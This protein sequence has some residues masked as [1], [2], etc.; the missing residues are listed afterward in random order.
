[1]DDSRPRCWDVLTGMSASR[2]DHPRELSESRKDAEAMMERR[3][4]LRSGV[5]SMRP[6]GWS[7]GEMGEFR[8]RFLQDHKLASTLELCKDGVSSDHLYE[9][10][11]GQTRPELTCDR[12]DGK[13]V[14]RWSSKRCY[15]VA[16][17]EWEV[18]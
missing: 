13:G 5:G 10:D 17:P 11:Y 3:G 16:V 12:S 9:D 6:W 8:S 2:R 1:M 18:R 15:W 4:C 14:C 7:L